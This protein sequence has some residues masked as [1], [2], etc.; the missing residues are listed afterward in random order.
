MI[1]DTP[2]ICYCKIE[3]IDFPSFL[4]GYASDENGLIYKTT[5]AGENWNIIYNVFTTHK[6]I[7][8][9]NDST[10][11]ISKLSHTKFTENGGL[12]W[13]NESSPCYGNK[14][15]FENGILFYSS[16]QFFSYSYDTNNYCFNEQIFNWII[17]LGIE[18]DLRSS[19]SLAGFC[20]KGMNGLSVGFSN[21]NYGVIKLQ[22]F[23]SVNYFRWIV[24]SGHDSINDIYINANAIYAGTSP[25]LPDQHFLKSI[26]NGQNWFTQNCSEPGGIS[27]DYIRKLMM[28]NDSIGFAVGQNNIYKTINSGGSLIQ[29]VGFQYTG[30]DDLT[31]NLSLLLYPNPATDKISVVI[32]DSEYYLLKVFDVLGNE[33][34]SQ[35]FLESGEINIS[36]WNLLFQLF[37]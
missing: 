3:S 31:E 34:I 6:G 26:D 24:F 20:G 30:I 13:S 25:Q 33:I 32:N 11:F 16:E 9:L 7:K 27:A 21:Q 37:K 23:S 29:Q 35:N 2:T 1:W 4:T 15:Q 10:G 5:D 19:D 28:A 17:D 12:S 36:Q 8:F 18:S 14:I 22:S